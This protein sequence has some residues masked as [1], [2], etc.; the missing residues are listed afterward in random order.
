[1][2][3]VPGL[4]SVIFACAVETNEDGIKDTANKTTAITKTFLFTPSHLL[5]QEFITKLTL[6]A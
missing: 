3:P 6:F 5:S 1:V 2:Y 4:I